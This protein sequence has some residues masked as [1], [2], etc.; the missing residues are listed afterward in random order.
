M[1]SQ[2]A[3]G[4][5]DSADRTQVASMVSSFNSD[6]KLKNTFAQAANHCKGE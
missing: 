5:G 4:N 3:D 1:A 2:Q 6:P